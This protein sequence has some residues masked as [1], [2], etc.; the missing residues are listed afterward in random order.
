VQVRPERG[1]EFGSRVK[2][3]HTGNRKLSYDNALTLQQ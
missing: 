1:F 2:R 3:K